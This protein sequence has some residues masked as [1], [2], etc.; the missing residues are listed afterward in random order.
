MFEVAGKLSGGMK[1]KLCV[2]ISLVGGRRVILLDEPTAGMDPASRQAIFQLLQ[3]CK[4]DRTILLTTHCMDE[5]DLLGD[6]IA[7]MVRGR[8]ICAGTSEFLKNR[9]GTGYLLSIDL[10][11]RQNLH[12]FDQK[13][14]LLSTIRKHIPE[15]EK[16]SA[17]SQQITV[18]LPIECKK[19]FPNLFI[20]LEQNAGKYGINSFGL[21]LNTLEQVFLKVG[22]LEDANLTAITDL[23]NIAEQQ[24]SILCSNSFMHT[25]LLLWLTQVTALLRKRFI[26]YQKQWS[27]LIYQILLPIIV[28]VFTVFYVK[29]LST[30]EEKKQGILLNAGR[31]SPCVVPV[32]LEDPE[33]LFGHNVL[34]VIRNITGYSHKL[35]STSESMELNLAKLPKIPP[36]VG[37][38]V[39]Y[40]TEDGYIAATVFFNAKARYGPVIAM[41]LVNNARLGQF[42]DSIEVSFLPYG[43]VSGVSPLVSLNS[44]IFLIAPILIIIFAFVSSGFVTYVVDD[45][46]TNFLHQQLRTRLNTFTYWLTMIIS[47]LLLYAFICAV[48]IAILGEWLSNL[49]FE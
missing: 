49:K 29:N 11:P 14:Q 23:E 30:R 38:A 21:S 40:N 42:A 48:F 17:T 46:N 31:I 47:D 13:E 34:Q 39:T 44:H 5:A 45:L 6:R 8:L 35:V 15:I 24:A 16:Q 4:R 9:F 28:L 2:G 36:P 32:Q 19:S 18:L 20:E 10:M 37:M 12:S 7:I 1:R 26:C 33:E 3:H 43:N 25:G 41:T 27:R 22:E